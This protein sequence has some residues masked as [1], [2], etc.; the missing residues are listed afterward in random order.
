MI[1]L[2]LLA[3]GLFFVAVGFWQYRHPERTQATAIKG[4]RHSWQRRIFGSEGYLVG[5]ETN[6][7]VLLAIG[8]AILLFVAAELVI[9]VLLSC[10]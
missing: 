7:I 2:V 10:T 4:A 5:A 6:G 3:I 8:C 1:R 9:G